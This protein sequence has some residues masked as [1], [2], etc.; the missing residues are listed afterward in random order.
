[1]INLG[2]REVSNDRN[3]LVQSLRWRLH[4]LTACWDSADHGAATSL[5]IPA[6]TL[7][8]FDVHVT[9]EMRALNV[10]FNGLECEFECADLAA[11]WIGRALSGEYQL[12]I[13]YVGERPWQWTL[14]HADHAAQE[15]SLTMGMPVRFASLRTKRT[16]YL[17]NA[18]EADL[19]RVT[20]S[21]G[22]SRFTSPPLGKAN[23]PAIT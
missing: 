9:A 8:G 17:R 10:S 6:T 23:R 20:R 16:Q 14:E 5:A 2:T 22:Q 3:S 21:S 13:D 1:V 12:R 4:E 7:G 11:L 18:G 19:P 15:S